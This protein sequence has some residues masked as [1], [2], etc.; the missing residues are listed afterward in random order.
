VVSPDGKLIAFIFIDE[1]TRSRKVEMIPAAGG[2]QLREFELPHTAGSLIR[3]S[4]DG[5]AI[6]FIVEGRGA[7]NVWSQSLKGGPPKQ[8]TD[9]KSDRINEFDWSPDGK[10]LAVSRYSVS[11]DVLLMSDQK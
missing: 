2:K 6:F 5:F 8:I 1:K 7:S 3:W 11:T 4:R 9:F 10:F